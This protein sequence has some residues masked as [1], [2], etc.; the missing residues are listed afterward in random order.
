M[1]YRKKTN[2]LIDWNLRQHPNQ[3]ALQESLI[4]GDYARTNVW[5]ITPSY[6][7]NHPAIFPDELV[8]RVLRYYSFMGDVVLDPFA[9]SGTVGRVAEQ[10]GRRF[11][12]IEKK[13]NYF[14][15]AQRSLENTASSLDIDDLQ[16]RWSADD[17]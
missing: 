8:N 5:D 6:T 16:Y 9:G 1:V 4:L 15:E 17:A 13:A 14:Y 12:I 11:V 2:R 3:E 10:M 7:K